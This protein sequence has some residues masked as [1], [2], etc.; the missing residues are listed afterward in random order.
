M[1]SNLKDS[2]QRFILTVTNN[3]FSIINFP[4][5][6]KNKRICKLL[7]RANNKRVLKEEYDGSFEL[8]I[9]RK[10]IPQWLEKHGYVLARLA[11]NED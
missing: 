4:K 3:K 11:Y 2:K 10:M 7:N 9:I 5:I 6:A 1:T 8:N